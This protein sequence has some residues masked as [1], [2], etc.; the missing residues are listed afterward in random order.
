[1]AAGE[2]GD[3]LQSRENSSIDGASA[4]EISQPPLPMI[5]KPSMTIASVATTKVDATICPLSHTT[6]QQQQPPTT[7]SAINGGKTLQDTLQHAEEDLERHLDFIRRSSES[8]DNGNGIIPHLRQS[9]SWMSLEDLSL[10]EL[11]RDLTQADQ[12]M[13]SM[14]TAASPHRLVVGSEEEE[15]ANGHPPNGS[16]GSIRNASGSKEEDDK[17]VVEEEEPAFGMELEP[18]QLDLVSTAEAHAHA[19]KQ[20]TTAAEDAP[21]DIVININESRCNKL[22]QEK[23][24]LL[25]AGTSFSHKL[26]ATLAVCAVLLLFSIWSCTKYG[27]DLLWGHTVSRCDTQCLV[28]ER[29]NLANMGGGPTENNNSINQNVKQN[30]DEQNCSVEQGLDSDLRNSRL[31]TSTSGFLVSIGFKS[32]IVPSHETQKETTQRPTTTNSERRVRTN[33]RMLIVN[34]SKKTAGTT[35]GSKKVEIA[36][37]EKRNYEREDS[38]DVDST[39]QQQQRETLQSWSGCRGNHRWGTLKWR[40]R[41]GMLVL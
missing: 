18:S 5:I 2:V 12:D 30:N 8:N 25:A 33:T 34:H 9:R 19:T 39:P 24:Q 37:D 13:R 16:Y 41:C 26:L 35:D 1:M 22:G 20:S 38:V 10:E 36:E 28:T 6:I 29:S 40:R 7:I 17:E 4:C 32:P 31:T 14:A 23:P 21:K 15:E 27:H 3:S 11:Q